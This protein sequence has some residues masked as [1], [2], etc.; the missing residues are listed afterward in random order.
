MVLIIYIVRVYWCIVLDF[1]FLGVD[2][3]NGFCCL[4]KFVGCEKF[5]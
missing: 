2:L 3:I 4:R 5:F 1:L